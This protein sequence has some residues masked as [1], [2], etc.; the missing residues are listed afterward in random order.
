MRK[1]VQPLDHL[2]HYACVEQEMQTEFG[3]PA[4][5]ADGNPYFVGSFTRI[6]LRGGLVRR[7]EKVDVA[8]KS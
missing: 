7:H 8:Q 2:I 6:H 1:S 4:Y 3:L 5:K